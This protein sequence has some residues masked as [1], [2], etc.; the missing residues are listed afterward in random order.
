MQ[1]FYKKPGFCI[2]EDHELRTPTQETGFLT[3]WNT[4][5]QDFYKKPGFC[6]QDYTDSPTI[7]CRSAIT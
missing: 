1:D 5:M 4:G 2:Q 6:I 3:V 7:A